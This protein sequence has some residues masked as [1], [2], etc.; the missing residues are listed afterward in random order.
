MMDIMLKIE[1]R[2]LKFGEY[3][4]VFLENGKIVDFYKEKTNSWWFIKYFEKPWINV[5]GKNNC[6]NNNTYFNLKE[7]IDIKCNRYYSYKM[8]L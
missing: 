7:S 3:I 5:N 1:I 6:L 4:E 8:S 2:K